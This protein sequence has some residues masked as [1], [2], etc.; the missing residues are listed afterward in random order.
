MGAAAVAL[1]WLLG[2]AGVAPGPARAQQASAQDRPAWAPAELRAA[3]PG[4]AGEGPAAVAPEVAAYFAYYG[5]DVAG[6]E[7]RFGTFPSGPFTLAA[8][9][10]TPARPRATVLLLHGYFDHTGTHARAIHHL[11]GQDFAVAAFDLPGHGLSSGARADIGHFSDYLSAFAD[12][13]R[14]CRAL[15]PPPYHAVAHS[16]GA[17]IVSTTLLADPGVALERVVLVAPLVR[18]AYWRL[19]LLGTSLLAPFFDQLPRVFRDNSS[20][21]AFTAFTRRDPLQPRHTTV[22]WIQAV[23]AWEKSVDRFAPNP[24]PIVIIQGDEDDIIDWDYN[25]AFLQGKFPNA[26]IDVI[27]GARHQLLDESPALRER[28]LA[29]IDDA[30]GAPASRPTAG[31]AATES[32]AP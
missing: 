26:R 16:T 5:L 9:L 27:P 7:H 18:S 2:L 20:D 11:L 15:M 28:V 4:L 24:K 32:V 10:F 13:R 22:D 31:R 29:L 3:L 21:P 17:A 14:L 6:V 12:F 1:T 25:L 19:S 8:H 30:L 23:A